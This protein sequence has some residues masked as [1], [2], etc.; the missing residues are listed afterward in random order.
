DIDPD[1]TEIP[2]LL[3]QPYV[4]N[5][6]QHGFKYLERKGKLEIQLIR[7]EETILC[8]IKDNGVGRSEAKRLESGHLKNHKSV[9]MSVSQRRLELINNQHKMTTSIAITDLM[10][11]DQSAGTMVEVRIPIQLKVA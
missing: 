5:A 10:E 9:G 8:R 2:F 1:G 3:L 11:Q 7:E 6:I 4:E